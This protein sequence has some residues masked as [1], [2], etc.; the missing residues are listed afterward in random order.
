MWL[1]NKR[2][3]DTSRPGQKG[4]VALHKQF[5]MD[6]LVDKEP[7]YTFEIPRNIQIIQLRYELFKNKADEWHKTNGLLFKETNNSPADT[8]EGEKTE[9]I[10]WA[11]LRKCQLPG[12]PKRAVIPAAHIFITKAKVDKTKEEVLFRRETLSAVVNPP[13]DQKE[14]TRRTYQ[15]MMI[16]HAREIKD[17]EESKSAKLRRRTELLIVQE[18]QEIYRTEY[19]QEKEREVIIIFDNRNPL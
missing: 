13:D 2:V 6:V 19:M 1:K 15:E 11:H 8:E 4:S 9:E 18:Q 14:I 17:G 5:R 16:A 12:K 7:V 10:P 3:N